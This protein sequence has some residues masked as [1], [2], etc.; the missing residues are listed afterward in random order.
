MSIAIGELTRKYRDRL[1]VIDTDL[2]S[3][4]AQVQL[5]TDLLNTAKGQSSIVILGDFVRKVT[6]NDE[7][8][9]RDYLSLI[10]QIQQNFDDINNNKGLPTS[11][12]L[13]SLVRNCQTGIEPTISD[14][15]S[16]VDIVQSNVD[17]AA[18]L[19]ITNKTL[20]ADAG[21]FTMASSDTGL[22]IT[23]KIYVGTA[24]FSLLSNSVTLTYSGNVITQTSFANPS[25]THKVWR[26]G[27]LYNG[28]LTVP[29]GYT[30]IT[31]KII[32]HQRYKDGIINIED[33]VASGS[34]TTVTWTPVFNGTDSSNTYYLKVAGTKG[35]SPNL[36]WIAR[37]EITVLPAIF[38]EGQAD[39]VID[40][41][42][43]GPATAKANNSNWNDYAATGRKI[44]VKGT[45]NA[46]AQVLN[47]FYWRST[48]PL[49]PIHV[50]FHGC[51]INAS[52]YL[53]KVGSNRNIILDGCDDETVPYGLILNKTTGGTNEC[54][55]MSQA[56]N[57]HDSSWWIMGGIK[58]DNGVYT[59]GGTGFVM[60]MANNA[61]FNSGT[62]IMDSLTVFRLSINNTNNEGG[63]LG[64]TIQGSTPEFTGLSNCLYYNLYINNTRNE[65]W[66]LGGH[67]GVDIFGN[68]FNNSGLG[69]QAG[70]NYNTQISQGNQNIFW[71]ANNADT[72][73]SMFQS[74]TGKTGGTSEIFCNKYQ[75]TGFLANYFHASKSSLYSSIYIGVFNNIW[76]GPNNSE[77]A[78]NFYNDSD[79]GTPSVIVN[80]C[81]FDSNII[82]GGSAT[83]YTVNNG[84][85]GSHITMNNIQSTDVNSFS[86]IDQVNKNFRPS[87]LAST[88]FGHSKSIVAGTRLHPLANYDQDGNAFVSTNWAFGPF[89]GVQLM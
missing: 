32:R 3:I 30:G 37:G 31:W 34:S 81:Y 25:Y 82:I 64:H 80:P 16:I 79:F 39:V 70:Q 73:Q 10:S 89:S 2:L 36:D 35:G 17:A 61:T 7:V 78:F 43:D 14:H 55:Y 85:D 69:L 63:Y 59:Q 44:Y 87:T 5:T 4:I 51:T 21:L 41:A 46:G 57:T 88:V 76:M 65:S 49:K 27:T 62:S 45:S 72:G 50:I 67:N 60:Q 33:V 58:I 15:L 29:T 38:T 68:T 11:L 19:Q 48:N 23:D 56:D 9:P 66:Q 26:A 1:I 12:V 22:T 53:L 54:V 84:F 52:T 6:S 8:L 74:F 77:K 40:L 18:I 24:A 86:F 28:T 47:F 13:G 42:V 75:T 20:V 71:S 83:N